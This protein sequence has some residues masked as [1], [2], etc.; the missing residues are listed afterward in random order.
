MALC[1]IA[2]V[3]VHTDPTS[4]SEFEIATIIQ[5]ATTEV[6]TK[7][8]STDE[9][10]KYLIQAGIHAAAAITLKRARSA[11]ELASSVKTP[12]SEISTTGIIEEIKQHEEE[13][14]NYIRLYQNSVYSPV[15]ASPTFNVGFGTHHHGGH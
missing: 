10:N 2:D 13:R 6:L 9:T 5:K 7:A 11:G 12:E 8:C 14:D 3:R 1:S 4:I 15:F